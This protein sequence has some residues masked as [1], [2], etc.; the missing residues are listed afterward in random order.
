VQ[1]LNKTEQMGLGKRQKTL[2]HPAPNTSTATT[3]TKQ[4]PKRV[5]GLLEIYVKRL[6]NS[7]W[8]P[9]GG[10]DIPGKFRGSKKT[11][12]SATRHKKPPGG[13]KTV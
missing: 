12:G 11:G 2:R 5:A 10:G 8:K 7:F 4:K 13:V 3:Q 9:R 1:Q 6:N